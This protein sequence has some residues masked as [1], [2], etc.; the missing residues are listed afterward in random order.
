VPARPDIRFHLDEGFLNGDAAFV[1]SEFQ[2]VPNGL[3]REA[4]RPLWWIGFCPT[5]GGAF[6]P[7]SLVFGV[8][9]GFALLNLR[10]HPSP[11]CNSVF[12]F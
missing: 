8:G 6:S 3:L 2:F 12:P 1:R 4:T 11:E 7:C 9:L 5:V 10:C